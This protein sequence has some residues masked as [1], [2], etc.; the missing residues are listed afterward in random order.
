[1]AA[2]AN[3]AAFGSAAGVFLVSAFDQV[4]DLSIA[5]GS[6]F[7]AEDDHDHAAA[8][9]LSHRREVEA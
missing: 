9:T 4:G 6:G 3:C 1:M 5:S 2:L 8:A 7:T